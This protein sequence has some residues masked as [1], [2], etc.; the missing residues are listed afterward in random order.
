MSFI[1]RLASTSTDTLHIDPH[2]FKQYIQLTDGSVTCIS[3]LS[4]QRPFIKLNIDSLTHPSWNVKLR[5]KM[6]LD[7]QGE[8]ARFR[9]RFGGGEMDYA[10]AADVFKGETRQLD[11]QVKSGT[12]PKTRGKRK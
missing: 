9:K 7:D 4:P 6:L 5:D 2:R 12:K 3:S 10:A 8:V 11:S 1:R